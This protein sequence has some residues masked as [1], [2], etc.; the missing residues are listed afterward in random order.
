MNNLGQVLKELRIKRGLRQIDVV[1]AAGIG[2]Q[3]ESVSAIERGRKAEFT[4][5]CK[6]AYA[7]QIT[8]NDLAVLLGLKVWGKRAA[9][10]E[11]APVVPA[12][13]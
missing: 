6:I 8:P 1:K 5:T 7:L 13:G 11:V 4:V 10:K 9:F 3:N 12:D 2:E